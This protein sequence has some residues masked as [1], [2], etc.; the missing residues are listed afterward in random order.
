ME[1]VLHCHNLKITHFL[2]DFLQNSM[3]VTESVMS[4]AL[5]QSWDHAKTAAG[6][7]FVSFCLPGSEPCPWA[8]WTCWTPVASPSPLVLRSVLLSGRN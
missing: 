6:S 1:A 4:Q 8:Q 5:K 3:R 7:L 2:V